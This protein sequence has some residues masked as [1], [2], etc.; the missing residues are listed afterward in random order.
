MHAMLMWV[1]TSTCTIW[2]VI[3]RV[4]LETYQTVSLVCVL[5]DMFSLVPKYPGLWACS[6]SGDQFL[7]PG[8]AGALP[9]IPDCAVRA[10]L[11]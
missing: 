1:V 6:G 5:A 11:G 10:G 8:M 3:P 4:V 2:V 7:C 9:G